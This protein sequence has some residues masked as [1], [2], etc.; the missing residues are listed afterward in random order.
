MPA[1]FFLLF[2]GCSIPPGESEVKD[3]IMRYFGEKGYRVIELHLGGVRPVPLGNRVYMGTEGY[4]VDVRSI[5]LEATEDS[6]SP[7][8]HRKDERL[9][10]RDAVFQ[11]RGKA[12]EKWAWEVS[13]I[14]GITVL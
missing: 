9:T 1:I 7:L 8:F 12:G 3:A 11:I 2:S 6:G 14:S 13:V 4:L 5:T 10:F